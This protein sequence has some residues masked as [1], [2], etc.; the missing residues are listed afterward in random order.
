MTHPFAR[1]LHH[2]GP[3]MP[4]PARAVFLRA[5]LGAALGIGICALLALVLPVKLVAPLGATAFLIFAVPN[6][7]LAQPWSAI[8]G[9][10]VAA[11]AALAVVAVAPPALAPMLAIGAAI[12]AMMLARA[13]HPPGGAVALLLALDPAIS[14]SGPAAALLAVS[15]PTAALVIAGTLFNRATGRVFPFRQPDTAPE[16]PRLGLLCPFEEGED[17]RLRGLVLGVLQ[18]L[19]DGPEQGDRRI[20]VEKAV[21]RL[22]DPRIGHRV[23]PVHHVEARRG[24]HALLLEGMD[25]HV[26]VLRIAVAEEPGRG[27]ELEIRIVL[28]EEATEGVL[29]PLRGERLQHQHAVVAPEELPAVHPVENQANRPRILRVA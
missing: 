18:R 22:P 2:L 10:T 7:P 6:A 27:A 11:G 9:N 12:L 26:Q 16:Q 5:P 29:H 20:V 23:E 17:R 15:L 19:Q 14:A 24:I 21:Q 4:T 25:D 13:L 3:A 28:L 1:H 8:V